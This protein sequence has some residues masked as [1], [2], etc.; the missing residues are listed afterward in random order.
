MLKATATVTRTWTATAAAT[1]ISTAS[2]TKNTMIPQSY[3]AWQV[4]AIGIKC[5]AIRSF[6]SNGRNYFKSD[7][8][9][10][11]D[12][13]SNSSSN[14]DSDSNTDKFENDTSFR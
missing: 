4:P 14:S 13:D 12:S 3:R 8:N 1:V 5:A 2:D 10:D 6:Y 9:N 7:G 11:S